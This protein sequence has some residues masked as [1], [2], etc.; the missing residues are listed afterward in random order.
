MPIEVI[1]SEKIEA[2]KPEGDPADQ[3]IKNEGSAPE[4]KNSK[5]NEVSD[6]DTEQTDEEIKDE[7]PE[8]ESEQSEEEQGDESEK[9][10]PKKK[11]G[12]QRR[13]DKLN[14]RISAREQELEY[15]KS[16]ALKQG[17]SEEKPKN[18][19]SKP[20]DGRPVAD[21]FE[22]HSDYLEALIDWKAEQKIKE[23]DLKQKKE[24]AE[25]EQEKLV[26]EHAERV[27]SF[28]KE[29]EDFQEVLSEVDDVPVS[30]TFQEL[31]LASENGPKLMY[32]LAKNREEFERINKLS[33][34]AAAREL[35]KFEAK[36]SKSTEVKPEI[37]KTTKAP[38]PITPVGSK[39]GHVDKSIYDESL[40][41][42]EYEALRAKQRKAG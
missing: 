28:S 11:G 41:Q 12:F 7:K 13:I 36:I 3:K 40:S 9:D 23:R 8:A 22:N 17:A 31:I 39:G 27:Q 15:W 35:G 4:S 29:V 24:Q 34:L 38:N 42:K 10:K 25:S 14:A 19:E 5:Q 2:V 18:V 1:T 16:Q 33:P 6:S 30:L 21:D 20:N 37:K 32:E 26:R